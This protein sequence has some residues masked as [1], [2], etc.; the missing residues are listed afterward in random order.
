[1]PKHQA[2][3]LFGMHLTLGASNVAVITLAV[4]QQ[5]QIWYHY[6]RAKAVYAGWFSEKHAL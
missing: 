6:A 2:E 5:A 4:G 3:M 1:M